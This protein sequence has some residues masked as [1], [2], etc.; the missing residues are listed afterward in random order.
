M[1]AGQVVH[2]PNSGVREGNCDYAVE[3]TDRA[4]ILAAYDNPCNVFHE[5]LVF[6]ELSA[7][8]TTY[9]R[10]GCDFFDVC[11]RVVYPFVLR[12]IVVVAVFFGLVVTLLVVARYGQARHGVNF[13]R[14]G[15]FR[16]GM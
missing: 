4:A 8:H 9:V 16:N 14:V 7:R 15:R 2:R 3:A 5:E 1:F 12:L 6:D 13:T 11:R 10:S